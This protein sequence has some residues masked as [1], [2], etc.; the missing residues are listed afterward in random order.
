MKPI[1]YETFATTAD[2]GIR[3]TG[4]DDTQ[5]YQNALNGLNH[6]YFETE[7]PTPNNQTPT[8]H[9]YE[10]HGDGPENLL[11]NL[12]S[13]ITYLLQTEEKITTGIQIKNSTDTHIAADLITIP[14]DTVPHLEIKSVTYH[15]L[16][17][18][19]E[20]GLLSAQVI[21]DV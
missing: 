18:K 19:K 8:I 10:Y 21:F 2:V 15:N 13:E 6:L 20:N 16:M 5:F 9:P 3:F 7:T 11:V 14:L 17:V 4:A 1:N 12:L